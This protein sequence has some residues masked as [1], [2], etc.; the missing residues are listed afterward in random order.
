[1]YISKFH[2]NKEKKSQN[3]FLVNSIERLDHIPV[4]PVWQVK[5]QTIEMLWPKQSTALSSTTLCT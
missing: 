2:T 4:V 5:Q 3:V 1:M